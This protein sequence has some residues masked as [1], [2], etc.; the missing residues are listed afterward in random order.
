[1]QLYIL[2]RDPVKAAQL[3]PDKYKFKMLIELGQLICS[4]GLSDVYKPIAQGKELQQWVKDNKLWTFK[5]FY[6]LLDW[7]VF[8]INMKAE[9]INKLTYIR[10]D[11]DEAI[12]IAI[13]FEGMTLDITLETAYFRYAEAY[14]RATRAKVVPSKTLLPIDECIECYKEYLIWK[15]KG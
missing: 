8:N 2:D 5:Y 3:I 13:D 10:N 1:M 12:G 15:M 4:A 9:T 14:N 7:S 6:E 11:L